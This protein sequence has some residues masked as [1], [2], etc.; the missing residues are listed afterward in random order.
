MMFEMRRRKP[1]PSLLLLPIRGI[2][3]LPQQIGILCED[4]AFDDAESLTQ[5]GNGI[6]TQLN[7]L[8]VQGVTNTL[9]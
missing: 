6:A 1:E 2:F 9:P 5:M 7:V 4:L 8:A 3:N